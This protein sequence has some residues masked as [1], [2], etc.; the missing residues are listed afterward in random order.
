M[1]IL[2]DV[3]F[4]YFGRTEA[5]RDSNKDGDGKGTV[6]RMNEAYAEDFDTNVLT[7][8]QELVQNTIDPRTCSSGFLP[9]LQFIP[10]VPYIDTDEAMN[11]KLVKYSEKFAG[12]RGTKL[13]LR[14]IYLNFM[15][16]LTFSI[17]E[18]WMDWTYDN[19]GVVKYDN[20]GGYKYDM[21]KCQQYCSEYSIALTGTPSTLSVDQVIAVFAALIYNEPINAHLRTLTYNGVEL[22]PYIVVISIDSDGDLI[23][24]N[25]YDPDLVLTLSP[26]GD[27][28]ISGPH[29]DKYYI[30]STGDLMYIP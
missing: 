1:F 6:Q 3:I 7:P 22:A 18:Y 29:K 21:S 16:M 23:Y 27:L 14:T 30:S 28:I 17:T 12:I 5:V 2:K 11:R 9:Y 8:T 19:G 15:G 4:S 24:N 25:T 10:G 13:A 20:T 26:D